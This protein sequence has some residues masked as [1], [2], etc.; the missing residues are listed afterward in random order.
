VIVKREPKSH[1]E[2]Q[3]VR[4]IIPFVP[5]ALRAPVPFAAVVQSLSAN[6]AEL[7]IIR[8]ILNKN[9]RP[10]ISVQRVSA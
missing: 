6:S 1:V 5:L 4:P 7:E 2:L 8:N 3:I 9:N 10:D